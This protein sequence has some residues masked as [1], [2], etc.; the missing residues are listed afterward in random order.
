MGI[1]DR[2]IRV[3]IAVI[4]GVLFFTNILTGT[5]GLILLV[6]SVL[7]VITSAISFCPIYSKTGIKTCSIK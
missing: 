4:V 7:F 6:L 2:V 1:V 3:L 5:L